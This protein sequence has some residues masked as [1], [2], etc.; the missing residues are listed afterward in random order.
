MGQE[1]YISKH[2]RIEDSAHEIEVYQVYLQEIQENKSSVS[3]QTS[4]TTYN[5]NSDTHE[6]IQYNIPTK[7]DQHKQAPQHEPLFTPRFSCLTPRFSKFYRIAMAFWC[8]LISFVSGIAHG[9][10]PQTLKY[11]SFLSGI[12]VNI[13]FIISI[14]LYSRKVQ[15]DTSSYNKF[16]RVLMHLYGTS[17]CLSIGMPI[18][19]W[20]YFPNY[21]IEEEFYEIFILNIYGFYGMLMLVLIA[22]EYVEIFM[23]DLW[24][25]GVL[26]MGYLGF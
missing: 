6:V 19:Y 21:L 7:L 17:L 26:I 23:K 18:F 9:F 24:S 13:Y 16:I 10:D 22:I 20:V 12:L 5:E 25:M 14:F 2:N 4:I 1:K 3:N 8:T 15:K 11:L